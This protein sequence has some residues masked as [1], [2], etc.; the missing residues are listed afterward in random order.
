MERDISNTKVLEAIGRLEKTQ[1]STT[2]VQQ[3]TN[4]QLLGA[5][6]KLD[7][8]FDAQDKKFAG[9]ESRFDDLIDFLQ[10]HMVTKEEFHATLNERLGK[11]NHKLRDYIDRKLTE[12]KGDLISL[13]RKGD[14][15]AIDL[16]KLL[17]REKIITTQ[18]AD[19]LL[20]QSY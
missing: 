11:L 12:L 7:E 9:M 17:Q 6:H 14:K 10:E 15:V 18:Q 5:I 1:E 8:R 4:E 19:Q 2:T 16:I 20:M 13:I 3:T